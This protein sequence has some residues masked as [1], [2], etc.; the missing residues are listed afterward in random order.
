MLS[1]L[2]DLFGH[3]AYADAAL[4]N[5]IRMH[6][7][8]ERDLELRTLMHHILVAHRFWVNICQDLPFIADGETK[9][10]DSWDALQAKYQETQTQER[11]F[12]SRLTEAHLNRTV[13]SPFFPGRKVPI[14]QGLMQVVLHSQG[15]RAQCATR[16]RALGG[17]PPMLDFILWVQ[18]RPAPVWK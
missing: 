9:V 4:L 18:D 7:P 11:G 1:M 15:H 16:L 6:E 14:E 5:A 3:Q 12:L 17:A 13:E 2:I 10:P 8:A